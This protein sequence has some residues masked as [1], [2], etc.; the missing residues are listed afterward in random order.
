MIVLK[1]FRLIVVEEALDRVPVDGAA[2]PAVEV[3]EE[4]T[5]G[6]EAEAEVEADETAE[7][8]AGTEAETETEEGTADAIIQG[9]LIPLLETTGDEEE[10]L[11]DITAV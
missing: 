6:L 5:V 4:G 7:V 1:K 2:D 11:T 3:G 10:T 9:T 8:E